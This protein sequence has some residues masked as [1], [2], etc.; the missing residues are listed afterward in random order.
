MK[1]KIILHGGF[2]KING[3][4]HINDEFFGEMLKDTLSTVKILLVYFAELPEKIPERIEQD[5]EQLNNNRGLKQLNFRIAEEETFKDDISWADVIYLHGGK[6]VRLM[7]YLNKYQNLK[8]L[9]F[10][11]IIAGDSAGANALATVFFSRNSGKIGRGIGLLP[12]KIVPHYE[13]GKPDPFIDIE[14]QLETIF[15]HEYETKVIYI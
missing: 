2:N 10:G 7:E 11:K 15:L 5:K 12:I 1:T 13:Y 9:F 3:P 6:T 14:P 8:E 4:I